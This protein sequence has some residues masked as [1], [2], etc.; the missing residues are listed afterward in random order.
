MLP[1][2]KKIYFLLLPLFLIACANSQELPTLVPTAENQIS[3]T[4]TTN[5]NSPL[6]TQTSEPT[7]TPTA[8]VTPV[9][10]TTVATSV[11]GSGVNIT[12]PNVGTELLLGS[13]LIVGGLVQLGPDDDLSVSLHD[14]SGAELAKGDIQLNDFNSWQAT[15]S[16]PDSIGGAGE[17]RALVQDAAGNV[18]ASDEQP[19]ILAVDKE[20]TGRYLELYRPLS[21]YD[22]VAGY[23]LFF[24]GRAQ[25]PTNNLLSVSVW[26]ENCSVQV[27]KQSY[28]LRGSGYWQGFIVIP[29]DTFG[30]VCA[31]ASFGEQASE[32]WREVQT[33]VN[34]IPSTDE[35]A[36]GVLIG[37]PP[38]NA[39]IADRKSLLVYG[40]A[41]NAPSETIAISVLLGN[42]RLLNE[43]VTS[44]DNN[45]YWEIDLY[46]PAD[47]NGTA[48]IKAFVGEAGDEDYVEDVTMVTID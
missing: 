46:I 12:T 7:F 30:E 34:V 39:V 43:G 6:A 25:L 22:A 44:V 45:G 28:R 16:V 8:S 21:G 29:R 40:T 42:G 38:P 1:L 33:T 13:E 47:A 32:D 27:A 31:I 37:N 20:A 26:T 41:F 5:P 3:L 15:I 4:V 36:K 19:V 35:K 14:A 48:Q 23:Y 11:V 17:I 24:D 10:P 9:L 2:C 18:V